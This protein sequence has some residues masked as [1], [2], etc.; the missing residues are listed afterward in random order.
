MMIRRFCPMSLAVVF[1]G[2][3]AGGADG[4]DSATAGLTA[5]SITS[6]TT[7]T[8][9][10]PPTG[11]TTAVVPSG[12]STS[13]ATTEGGTTQAVDGGSSSSG[14]PVGS[15]TQGGDDGAT[16][17][18]A[19]TGAGPK[20]DLGGASETGEPAPPDAKPCVKVDLLFVIDNSGSMKDE[21]AQLIASFP[22]FVQE[23]QQQLADAE[24]LHIGVVTT[25]EYAFNEAPCSGVLGGLV[26]ET[27][28]KDSSAA[29][30]GPY[31]GG[32]FMTEQDDLP[33]RFACA[34]Q[35]GTDGD[36]NERPIDAALYA[37]GPGLA[38]KGAC[39]DGFA[40]DDALLVLVLIT[41][42]EEEGSVGDPP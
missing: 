18:G 32:R 41:D 37:L 29:I 16:S 33:Q 7:L 1:A 4:H 15:S 9:A 22:V 25:D 34:G 36:G 2:A 24:S 20:F 14:A 19:T 38:A 17:G 39:N 31:A 5:V 10:E 21:Q 23:I 12:L 13:E 3:C 40:R 35:V 6:A 8:T 28:G 11:G 30:C 27:G 42:E 26:T